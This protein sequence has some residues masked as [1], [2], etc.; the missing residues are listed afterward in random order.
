MYMYAQSFQSCPTPCSPMDCSPSGSSVHGILQARILEWVTMPSSRGSSWPRDQT[1]VS[2][3]A[4]RFFTHWAT[5]EVHQTNKSGILNE[6]LHIFIHM[7]G[8]QQTVENSS[9]DG[10]TRPPDLPPEKPI[11]RSGS[12]SQNWTW[13]NGLVPNRKKSTSRLY[14]VTL[15]I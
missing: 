14:I 7:C 9:R 15:L 11:C 6:D 1:W 2:H 5:W 12:N 8:S 3:I 13:N 4:G 10:N